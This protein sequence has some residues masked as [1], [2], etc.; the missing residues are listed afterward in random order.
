MCRTNVTKAYYDFLHQSFSVTGTDQHS[1]QFTLVSVT[2]AFN[3]IFRL[4]MWM[5]LLDSHQ[6]KLIPGDQQ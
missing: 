2:D 3:S 5:D 1:Q 6:L 4:Y